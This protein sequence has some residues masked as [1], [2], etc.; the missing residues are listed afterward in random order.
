MNLKL[1]Q[2]T[3]RGVPFQE[4]LHLTATAPVLLNYY[5]VFHTVMV[6]DRI[7]TTPKHVFWFPETRVKRGDNIILYSKGGSPSSTANADGTTNHFFF[8]GLP[9]TIWDNPNERAT[10]LEVASWLTI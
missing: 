5:V 8:W 6:G 1:V 7:N 2:I 3:D 4:R 9:N 10:V